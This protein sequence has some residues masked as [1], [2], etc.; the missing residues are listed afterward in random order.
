MTT[1]ACPLRGHG[2]TP[3]CGRTP[4]ELPRTDRLTQISWAINCGMPRTGE[5]P[6]VDPYGLAQSA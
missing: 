4:F 2:V 3:C 6:G 5:V 1:H